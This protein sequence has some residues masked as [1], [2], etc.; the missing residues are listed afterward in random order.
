[1]TVIFLNN[2]IYRIL[3]THLTIYILTNET[4]EIYA[5]YTEYTIGMY[6]Y[7]L[8]D[9]KYLVPVLLYESDFF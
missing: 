4:Y 2:V 3:S 7:M 5:A 8:E 9:I 6:A 1:M